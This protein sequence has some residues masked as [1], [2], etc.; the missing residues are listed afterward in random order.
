MLQFGIVSRSKSS[1]KILGYSSLRNIRNQNSKNSFIIVS[2]C[3]NNI[4]YLTRNYNTHGRDIR[5]SQY[6]NT[7][8]NPYLKT[9]HNNK[10]NRY[11]PNQL[12]NNNNNNNSSNIGDAAQ[13]PNSIEFEK[14][15]LA[16]LIHLSNN[17]STT[18][19]QLYD[20]GILDRSLFLSVQRM[21]FPNLT[22]VQQKT[23]KPILLNDSNDNDKQHDIITRAKTGT[24]KTFS[25]LIPIFQHLI[26]TRQQHQYMVKA[27]II[28]PTRDL[29]LQIETEVKKLHKNNRVLNKYQCVSLVGGTNLQKSLDFM[30][31]RRPNI[32]IATPGRF[33]DILNRVGD[34]FF[35]FVDFKVLD[36]ADRLLEIGFKQ[37]LEHISTT[38]N[39][40]S[41]N[42]D[43]HIRT[44]LFSATLDERVQN[45]A[46]NIMN[47]EKCL[48]IDTIDK[49]EPEA[50]E[51]I[52]QSLVVSKSFA[53]NICA[54]IDHLK[55]KMVENGNT[56]TNYK[57]I[58]FTPTVKF[59]KLVNSILTREFDGDQS[60]PVYEFHGQV[61]QSRRT[62]LVRQF[63]NDSN[64]L[65]ICTDVAA[66]GMDFPN[67]KEVLQIGVPTE[68]ANYI[69]RIGRTARSGKDG[70]SIIFLCEKELP[71][72]DQLKKTKNIDIINKTQYKSTAE[73]KNNLA[74]IL[75]SHNT[76]LGSL[77]ES[78]I[79]LISYY[80]SCIKEY[81]FTEKDILPEIAKTYGLLLNEPDKKLPVTRTVIDR[82]GLTRNPISK[83]MFQ[84]KRRD[85]NEE[86]NDNSN[87]YRHAH[88]EKHHNYHN[89]THTK[90][91]HKGKDASY[92]HSKK[93]YQTESIESN[94]SSATSR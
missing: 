48:F 19:Q 27:V 65:L 66:R 56:T 39:S 29:A 43:R 77:S 69:H 6:H 73:T 10:Y 54:A 5:N 87:T 64:G 81:R 63:K 30:Y 8:H 92:S 14:E 79:S 3:L 4:S 82:L 85:L 49:N 44:L 17:D 38:L 51:K 75:Q 40:L 71:F 57:A 9:K 28:A 83:K 11:R 80:R 41:F 94:R 34:K 70:K 67:V 72:I 52:E 16:K 23:I 93:Y 2:T 37:D 59:T 24:G 88:R 7:K 74:A 15:T 76:T 35:K 53:D 33:I 91:L 26:N 89:Y 50:H 21:N 1:L 58:L 42:G 60:F 45:L 84:I 47:K 78:I 12:S 86:K 68:L 55:S 62:N 90:P 18:L 31:K 32:V 22:P 20:E 25:F 46:N 61:S 13:D 36:E